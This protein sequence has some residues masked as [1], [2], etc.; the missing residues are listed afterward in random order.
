MQVA[1][2][3]RPAQ[4]FE[5]VIAFMLLCDDMLKMERP[6]IAFFGQEAVFATA[7]GAFPYEL[8]SRSIHFSSVS[9]PK[10]GGLWI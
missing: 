9:R 10:N 8:T 5:A 4:V 3:A 2:A 1:T 7:A 6:L